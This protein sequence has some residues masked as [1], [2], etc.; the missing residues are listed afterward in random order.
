MTWLD[1]II[2]FPCPHHLDSQLTNLAFLFTRAHT[3]THTHTLMQGC[4]CKLCVIRLS[5]SFWDIF[6][7]EGTFFRAWEGLYFLTSLH[8]LT[9]FHPTPCNLYTLHA[10]CLYS[11]QHR[12]SKSVELCVQSIYTEE[13]SCIH[14]SHTALVNQPGIKVKVKKNILTRI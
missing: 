8:I 4:A 1:F 6:T 12:L 11:V 9:F 2:P 13:D 5:W 3:N 10:Y 7:H 14:P